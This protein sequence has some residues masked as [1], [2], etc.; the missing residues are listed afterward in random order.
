MRKDG[1][2]YAVEKNE[3]GNGYKINIEIGQDIDNIEAINCIFD[4]CKKQI[5]K[6]KIEK[7]LNM[8]KVKE[9]N[10]QKINFNKINTKMNEIKF[11]LGKFDS[12]NFKTKILLDVK[13]IYDEFNK[14]G[15]YK[16][17]K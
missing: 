3:E 9:I 11:F 10:L 17:D 16:E 4:N 6:Y 7:K 12:Y 8:D 1:Y 14:Y 5:E 15:V 13:E 2:T